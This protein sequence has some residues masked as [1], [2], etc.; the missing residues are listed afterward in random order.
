MGASIPQEY[1]RHFENMIYLPMVISIFR[2]DK[3]HIQ[4]GA[5][6][7]KGPYLELVESACKI[8]EKE[9]RETKDYMRIHQLKIETGKHDDFATEYIFYYDGFNDKRKYMNLRLRNRTE[10]LISVYLQQAATIEK[11]S[12]DW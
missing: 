11:P 10:E 1:I 2:R 9:Y 5:F 8:A 7:L 6:K 12:A 4:D 3:Q